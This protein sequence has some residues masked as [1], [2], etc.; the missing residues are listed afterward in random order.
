MKHI[1]CRFTWYMSSAP[2]R[3][4]HFPHAN[5]K[6]IL[7]KKCKTDRCLN[8]VCVSWLGVLEKLKST[9][10]LSLSKSW[11]RHLDH[12]R[13]TISPCLRTAYNRHGCNMMSA[14]RSEKDLFYL[15][16]NNIMT[17]LTALYKNVHHQREIYF[18]PITTDLRKSALILLQL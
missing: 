8:D 10:A 16:R 18:H 2:M 9:A 5:P 6:N 13:E 12:S 15:R 17:I 1:S 11:T 4:N 14:C 7:K 3:P